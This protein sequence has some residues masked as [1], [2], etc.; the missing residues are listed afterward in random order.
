MA[1]LPRLPVTILRRFSGA[2]HT[3]L[4]KRIGTAGSFVFRSER[5]LD[6]SQFEALVAAMVQV[7]GQDLLRY[8]GVLHLADTPNRVVFQGVDMVMGAEIGRPCAQGERRES[9]LVFIGRKLPQDVFLQG[10]EPCF[11]AAQ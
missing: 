10:L 2:G 4:P 7:Y 1:A 11:V 3:A 9:A 5:P 6:G 8:K